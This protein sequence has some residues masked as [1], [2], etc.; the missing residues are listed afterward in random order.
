MKQYNLNENIR[1][2][3]EYQEGCP[4][5]SSDQK[6]VYPFRP[7]TLPATV[8]A[9]VPTGTGA[10]LQPPVAVNY[11]VAPVVGRKMRLS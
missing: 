7:A 6:F 4:G 5:I 11:T 10:I 2:L 1:C 3:T 9:T 8:P